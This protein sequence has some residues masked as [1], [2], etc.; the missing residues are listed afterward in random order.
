LTYDLCGANFG[1]THFKYLQYNKISIMK[2]AIISTAI[3]RQLG[4]KAKKAFGFFRVT[5]PYL[6]ALFPREDEILLF[7]ET[8]D[9]PITLDKILKENIDFVCFSPQ[10]AS[11]HRTYNLAKKLRNHGVFVVI[12][13]VH[14]SNLPD[15]AAKYSHAVVVG[16]AESTLPKLIQDFKD[17]TA[18]I[19]VNGKGKIIRSASFHNMKKMVKPRWELMNKS[20]IDYAKTVE[21]ARGCP[22]NCDFCSVSD[23]FGRSYRFRPVDEVVYEISKLQTKH[24]LI[25]TD[26]LSANKNYTKLLLRGLADLKIEWIAQATKDFADDAELLELAYSAGCKVICIGFESV[27]QESR[28][29]FAKNRNNNNTYFDTVTK[30]HDA[31]IAVGGSFIFGFDHDK[32]GISETTLEFCLKS[33]IDSVSAHLLTPYPGT[34]LF[35]KLK[36]AK[37]IIKN[38]FPTDWA[39]YDTTNVVFKPSHMTPDKLQQEF[40]LF[41]KEFFSFSSILKRT[42]CSKRN[43]KDLLTYLIINSYQWYKHK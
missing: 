13:G 31:G 42:R 24:V 26:N 10:T 40:D 12:G 29:L 8:V 16:E 17:G 28:N 33:K 18:L 38:N 21:I 1:L 30:I 32:L 34:P 22:Y 4:Q 14:A 35:S 7:D 15:E 3:D 2:S 5:L 19:G 6:A 9:G 11:A 20:Y 25:A 41:N 43:V 36:N 37:R 39:L 27:S 23:L